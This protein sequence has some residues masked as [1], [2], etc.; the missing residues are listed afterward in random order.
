MSL[1]IKGV[2]AHTLLT[3]KEAA[4]VIDHANASVTDGKI[5]SGVGTLDTQLLKLPVAAD[6][7]VIK[8]AGGV[9]G[10]GSGG[11]TG[12]TARKNSQMPVVG[13]R[14]QLNLVE[15]AAIDIQVADNAPDNEIDLTISAKYPTQYIPLIPND[16]VLP[17]ANPP[18]RASVDGANFSYDVLDF[19]QAVEESCFWDW[20]L[21]PDYLSENIEVYIYW[22]SAGA[23]NVKF[24]VSTLGRATAEAWDAALG[25]EQTVLQPTAGA[26]LVNIAKINTFSPNWAPNDNV[27][28]KLARK[29]ADGADTLNADAR[30]LKVVIKYTGQFSQSFYPLAAAV[31]VSPVVGAVWKTVDVSAYV[32][33]GATGVILHLNWAG[34][35]FLGLRKKGSTDD[36]TD[37]MGGHCWAMIGIDSNRQFECYGGGGAGTVWLVGYTATGVVFFDNAYEKVPAAF[38]AWQD[39]DVSVECP[40]AIG[41]IVEMED[42]SGGAGVWAT[43]RKNGSALDTKS[44]EIRNHLWEVAGCDGAQIFE[45]YISSPPASKLFV[46]GYITSGAVFPTT[47]VNITP[48]VVDSWQVVNCIGSAPS[49]IMI[50]AQFR[51]PGLAPGNYGFRKNG[52]AEN[53]LATGANHQAWAFFPCDSAQ[54]IEAWTHN[55]FDGANYSLYLFGYATWAP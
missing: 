1:L 33:A 32:P 44:G 29:A 45:T 41:V 17:A 31:D 27:I 25:V 37:K 36:R 48:G 15:G 10:A 20:F 40:N 54:K 5:A 13:V 35:D 42:V 8:R 12:V 9:W 28:F 18:A 49:G 23:G 55:L 22:I 6:G 52:S 30:V 11:M 46:V 16:A 39:I 24:G 50:F 3:D 2:T 7:L 38:N 53:I 26:G 14:P 43:V 51:E 34:W 19:D 21:T 4:G 47:A